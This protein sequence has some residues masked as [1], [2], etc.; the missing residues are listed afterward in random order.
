MNRS[1]DELL[2]RVAPVGA[3]PE[4]RARALDAARRARHQPRPDDVWSRMWASRTL[5]LAWAASLASLLIAHVALSVRPD[6]E[7]TPAFGA[8]SGAFMVASNV[9]DDELRAVV[10]L[11]PII[12]DTLP[13]YETPTLDSHG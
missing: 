13:S 7:V 12:P 3:P 8:E 2:R 4:L 10:D 9:Q 11:P 1:P 6:D 5:R